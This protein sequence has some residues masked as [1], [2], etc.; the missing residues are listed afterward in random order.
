MEAVQKIIIE[1]GQNHNLF[2]KK[3]NTGFENVRSI[4]DQIKD[5]KRIE[6]TKPN[7]MAHIPTQQV[8]LIF[9]NSLFRN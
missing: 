7:P 5:N 6:T 3:R 8:P 4:F 2:E 9:N 1:F